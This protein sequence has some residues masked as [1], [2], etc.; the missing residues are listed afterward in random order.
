MAQILDMVGKKYGRL[1]VISFAQNKRVSSGKM[2]LFWN[3]TCSCG[4]SVEK[5]G[6]SLRKGRTR[7]CGCLLQEI[8]DRPRTRE[9]GLNAIIRGMKGNAKTRDLLWS[10]DDEIVKVLMSVQCIY[11]GQSPKQKHPRYPDVLYNG[12]DRID[13]SRGYEINNVV[14]CCGRCNKAKNDMSL[15]EFKALVVNIYE[16]SCAPH[17]PDRRKMQERCL[18]T[19]K[20]VL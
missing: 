13:S 17:P 16:H 7:S 10:L 3:C 20:D 9:A 11:C 6:T 8:Y 14:P 12:L 15:E 1:T 5:E 18:R 2:V 4:K 19:V